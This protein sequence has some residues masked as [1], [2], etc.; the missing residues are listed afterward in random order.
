[1]IYFQLSNRKKIN[2][3]PVLVC[4]VAKLYNAFEG[5]F[6]GISITSLFSDVKK[7]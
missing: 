4:W 2:Y 1:M 5:Y 3:D 7:T 6:M